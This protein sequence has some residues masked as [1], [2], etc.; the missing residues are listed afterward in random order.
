VHDRGLAR[1]VVGPG[2]GLHHAADRQPLCLEVPVERRV[3]GGEAI[4]ERGLLE[5]IEKIADLGGRE[6]IAGDVR[7]GRGG[8]AVREACGFLANDLPRGRRGADRPDRCQEKDGRERERA[9][10]RAAPSAASA[11][12]EPVRSHENVASTA[13][14]KTPGASAPKRGGSTRTVTR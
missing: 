6:R 1:D 14:S 2:A 11:R 12:A 10:H 3:G 4:A 9:D 7:L 13:S 5:A 8:E